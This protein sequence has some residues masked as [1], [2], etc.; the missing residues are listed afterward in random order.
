MDDYSERLI[1][2]GLK[3]S[4]YRKLKGL[5]QESLAEKIQVSLGFM[6]QIEAPNIV[7]GVSL[8]TLFDLE[9]A[10]GVPAYKFIRFDE[11]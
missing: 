4:Y 8:K 3:I 7:R 2:M 10:L 6:A 5:S 9:K 1:K 11:D